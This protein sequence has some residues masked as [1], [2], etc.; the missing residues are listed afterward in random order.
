MW[1]CMYVEERRCG[2]VRWR[3]GRC[4]VVCN[5]EERRCGGVRWRRGRCGVVCNVGERRRCGGVRW[6]RGRRWCIGRN[7]CSVRYKGKEK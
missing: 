5:V 6:R 4:G 7:K 2:G 1:C 3:R